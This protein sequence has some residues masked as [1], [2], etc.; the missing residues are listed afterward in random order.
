MRRRWR[1][2]GWRWRRLTTGQHPHRP[3]PSR[4]HSALRSRRVRRAAPPTAPTGQ[5]GVAP[6]TDH[7]QARLLRW[8]GGA[9]SHRA[10]ITAG[11]GCRRTGSRQARAFCGA[12]PHRARIASGA[13]RVGRGRPAS[14]RYAGRGSRQTRA[15][16]AV[17]A[18]RRAGSRRPACPWAGEGNRG[19]LHRA[20]AV[21]GAGGR[22]AG[23]AV[24][25]AVLVSASRW[26]HPQAGAVSGGGRPEG[27]GRAG[28]GGGSR[29]SRG[30][31][32]PGRVA[33]SVSIAPGRCSGGGEA[34][35]SGGCAGFLVVPTDVRRRR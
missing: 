3:S 29:P 9:G 24:R 1:L 14:R 35:G 27:L 34:E 25:R 7:A 18:S 10:R 2:W 19:A 11:R 17:G 30:V 4:S 13:D 31:Q 6:R 8:A 15:R 22:S 5:A 28:T 12:G 23:R 21:G 32:G 33:H 16:V 20:R 26:R